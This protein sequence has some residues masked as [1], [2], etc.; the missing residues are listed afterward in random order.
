MADGAELVYAVGDDKLGRGRAVRTSARKM[1]GDAA[2][3]DELEPVRYGP[4]CST[5][6]EMHDG[7]RGGRG[8]VGV[9]RLAV[10]WPG[11]WRSQTRRAWERRRVAGMRTC[12]RCREAELM[13]G[14]GR[15]RLKM[16]TR[17]RTSATSGRSWRA[18]L[19][20]ACWEWSGVGVQIK[21]DR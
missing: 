9:A 20:P 8:V 11:C 1:E 21:E 10:A 7:L 14:G 17:A 5:R 3:G 19:A 4:S 15:R 12:G 18:C 2:V 13:R 16:E 6:T